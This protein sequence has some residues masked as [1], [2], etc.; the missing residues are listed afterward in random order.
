MNC[1]DESAWPRHALCNSGELRNG[2]AGVLFDV[3]YGGQTCL[4]FAVRAR[5]QVVAYL[6]RC[7]HVA[8]EMDWRPGHFFDA[9]GQ[10]LVCST[11][12][13]LYRPQDGVCVQGP[14]VGKRLQPIDLSERDGVV[15]WHERH[16]VKAVVF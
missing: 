5:G 9:S 16:N 14:C 4:G 1:A 3:N 11:H 13:A 12:G 8:M 6:N 7:A 10:W 15:Y 2:G